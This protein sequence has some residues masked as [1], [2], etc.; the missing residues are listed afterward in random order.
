MNL[1]VCAGYSETEKKPI[2]TAA[3]SA[4]KALTTIR[5]YLVK[6]GI[7]GRV[8]STDLKQVDGKLI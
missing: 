6:Q 1:Y 3:E 4:E 7:T 8:F 2:Y 5:A